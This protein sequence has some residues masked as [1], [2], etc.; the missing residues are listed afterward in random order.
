MVLPMSH[1]PVPSVPDQSRRT[2]D[3]RPS[4]DSTPMAFV[5]QSL[6]VPASMSPPLPN[7][8]QLTANSLPDDTQ[9]VNFGFLFRNIFGN[10]L[11]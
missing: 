3:R 2:D 4:M 11:F 5:R 7:I 9:V 6:Q 10:C 1:R 8:R